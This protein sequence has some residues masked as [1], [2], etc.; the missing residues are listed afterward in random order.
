MSDL[1][2]Y[3][4][5]IRVYTVLAWTLVLSNA[6]PHSVT[7]RIRHNKTAGKQIPGNYMVDMLQSESVAKFEGW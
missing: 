3:Y 1:I 6:K 7:D 2:E 4:Y 5:P